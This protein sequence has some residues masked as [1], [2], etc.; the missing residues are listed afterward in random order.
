MDPEAS[1]D[2]SPHQSPRPKHAAS[3]DEEE[4][5]RPQVR[6]KK[7]GDEPP[8]RQASLVEQAEVKDFAEDAMQRDPVPTDDEDEQMASQDSGVVLSSKLKCFANVPV[9]FLP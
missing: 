9:A 6:R 7:T 2:G 4:E 1:H 8:S 5:E 3:S